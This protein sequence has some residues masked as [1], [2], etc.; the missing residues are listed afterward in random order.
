MA[1]RFNLEHKCR[2]MKPADCVKYI[3]VNTQ[4]VREFMKANPNVWGFIVGDI[5]NSRHLS[6]NIVPAKFFGYLEMEVP[7]EWQ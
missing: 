3:D 6:Y 4:A 1:R 7:A 5:A 2:I